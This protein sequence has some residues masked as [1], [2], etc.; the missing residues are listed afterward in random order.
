MAVLSLEFGEDDSKRKS[1]DA[2]MFLPRFPRLNRPK[3]SVY[4]VDFP[5]VAKPQVGSG[6]VA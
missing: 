4:S 5:S 1:G 3:R 2:M 6:V